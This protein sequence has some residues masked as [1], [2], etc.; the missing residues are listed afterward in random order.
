MQTKTH[1]S[2]CFAKQSAKNR[3]KKGRFYDLYCA[4]SDLGFGS[5]GKKGWNETYTK[6]QVSYMHVDK[7]GYKNVVYTR[8]LTCFMEKPSA[9]F[10]V[11]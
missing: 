4:W 7:G 11:H 1:K 10:G 2:L 5:K 3:N 8:V 9:I 6:G